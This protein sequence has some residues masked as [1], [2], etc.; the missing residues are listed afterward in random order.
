MSKVVV[1]MEW[2]ESVKSIFEQIRGV[3]GIIDIEE[4]G[5][6]FDIVD[7]DATLFELGQEWGDTQRQISYEWMV[8]YEWM[9]PLH[10]CVEETHDI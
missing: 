5:I 1:F 7:P 6:R 2:P 9:E 3:G 4:G 8:S 10:F